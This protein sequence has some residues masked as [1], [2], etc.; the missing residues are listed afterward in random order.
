M[1]IGHEKQSYIWTKRVVNV[2][3]RNALLLGLSIS[4]FDRYIDRDRAFLK[5]FYRLVE[6]NILNVHLAN[7]FTCT[8]TIIGL[9][10][11]IKRI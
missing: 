10:I 4:I 7:K 5:Q 11:I 8:Q 2:L 9:I 1:I 3:Q 6:S